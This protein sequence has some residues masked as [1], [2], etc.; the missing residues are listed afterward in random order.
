MWHRSRRARELALALCCAAVVGC[1]VSAPAGPAFKRVCDRSQAA[2]ASVLGAPVALRV[3]DRDAANIECLLDRSG[4][5]IDTV[6]QASTQAWVEYSTTIV[7]LQQAFGTGSVH[8]PA[9]LPI[10][11]H[12]KGALASWVPAQQELVTT[13][14]TEFRGGSYLT[15]TLTREPKHWGSALRLAT[16]VATAALAVAPRGQNPGP[17]PS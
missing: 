9:H 17:P 15:V 4:V 13:N 2:A 10:T 3:A 14:G 12:I 11:V 8:E 7:H 1:G 6:A 16:A 5:R